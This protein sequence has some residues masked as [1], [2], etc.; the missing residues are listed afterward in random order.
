M[1]NK[2]LFFLSKASDEDSSKLVTREQLVLG[3]KRCLTSTAAF[4]PFCLPLLTEKLESTMSSSK[5][6]TLAVLVREIFFFQSKRG[7]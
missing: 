5:I 7:T 6:D 3:L 2:V 4:A 1:Q